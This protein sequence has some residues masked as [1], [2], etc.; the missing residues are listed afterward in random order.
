MDKN[1]DVSVKNLG[2]ASGIIALENHAKTTSSQKIAILSI[3]M[4]FSLI[5]HGCLDDNLSR[6]K[7]KS[8]IIEKYRLPESQILSFNVTEETG[9]AVWAIKKFPREV[10]QSLERQ[11][12]LTAVFKNDG[13]IYATLTD[14]GKK[15]A[16]GD[17]FPTHD[18]YTRSVNVRTAKI[19]FGEI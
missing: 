15:Y 7:A 10:Y 19:I 5:C 18:E 8:L 14:Q 4:A 6:E 16:V 3:L 9:P 17:P 11:G 13:S 2:G 12:S 1:C